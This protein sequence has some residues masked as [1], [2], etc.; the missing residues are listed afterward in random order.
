MTIIKTLKS[1]N[2]V[3]GALRGILPNLSVS[4]K[5]IMEAIGIGLPQWDPP[6]PFP[7][8]PPDHETVARVQE[9]TGMSTLQERKSFDKIMQTWRQVRDGQP[10][11]PAQV[12]GRRELPIALTPEEQRRGPRP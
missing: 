7:P 3:G 2:A 1:L 6:E 10:P 9:A 4:R 12:P 5:S 8:S 11:Q